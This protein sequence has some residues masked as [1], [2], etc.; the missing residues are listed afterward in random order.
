[1]GVPQGTILS[2]VLFSHKINNIVKLVFKGSEASL[3]V[4]DF[5]FCIRAKFL[6][7]AQ[8]LM[9]LCVNNVQDW[10][11]SNGFELSTSKTDCMHF[12]NQ[13]LHFD[14]PFIMLD[15]N[16]IK[17]AAKARFLGVIF[18]RTLS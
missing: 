12:C 15:K 6:L 10:V 11:S 3:F 14:E 16:P 17:L 1:M 5:A 9:Q 2:P 18:D 8:R 4:E 13:R 7:H